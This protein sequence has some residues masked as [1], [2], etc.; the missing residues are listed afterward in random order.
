[1]INKY[2]KFILFLLLINFS[3]NLFALMGDTCVL[4]GDGDIKKVKDL[5]EGDGLLIY[6]FE[7]KSVKC[8]LAPIKEI[9]KYKTKKLVLVDTNVGY[10]KVG[11]EQKLYNREALKFVEAQ[12]LKVGDKLYSPELGE[13][14]ITDVYIHEVEKKEYLY[15]IS[16]EGENIFFILNSRG[17]PIV[18]HNFIDPA[19]GSLILTALIDSSV[20]AE[21]LKIGVIA[22][23]CSISFDLPKEINKLFRHTPLSRSYRHKEREKKRERARLAE[24]EKQRIKLESSKKD[25]IISTPIEPSKNIDPLINPINTENLSKPLIN[26]ILDSKFD[27]K[28]G[29]PIEEQKIEIETYPDKSDEL[30]R[31][32][33]FILNSEKIKDPDPRTPVGRK[34]LS[35]KDWKRLVNF[36]STTV[37]GIE[38]SDHAIDRMNDRGF[39]PSKI[40]NIIKNGQTY[41]NKKPGRIT[42]YDPVDDISVVTESFDKKVVTVTYGKL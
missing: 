3:N 41:E 30:N 27:I 23:I 32:E 21:L 22:G 37:N 20:G 15:D 35:E 38:Y 16:I 33:T 26:P 18:V 14:F 28:T 42:H 25:N 7:D 40:E 36:E 13:F 29:V 9:K 11:L 2:F 19:T 24:L 6:S 8:D 5:K 10:I 12:E 31:K 39:V 1:M 17:D 4:I 34:G